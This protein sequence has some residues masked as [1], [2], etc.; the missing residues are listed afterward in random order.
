MDIGLALELHNM[1]KISKLKILLILVAAAILFFVITFSQK[2]GVTVAEKTTSDYTA[3]VKSI[4]N[5][6]KLAAKICPGIIKS[7]KNGLPELEKNKLNVKINLSYKLMADCEAASLHH[8]DAAMYYK[9]LIEAEPQVARWHV[10]FA[11]SSFRANNIAESLRAVHLATQLDPKRLEYRLLEAR[12]LA[13]SKLYGKA[14][15]AYKGVLNLAPATQT[16]S[17][18][19]ELERVI[20]LKND[21]IQSTSNEQEMS[22]P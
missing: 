22:K 3:K 12:M 1:M 19:M 7:L 4:K 18:K 16:E 2:W 8:A 6:Y 17:I 9:K 15:I 11:E 20:A 10:A 21:A 13:K 14:I 5:N